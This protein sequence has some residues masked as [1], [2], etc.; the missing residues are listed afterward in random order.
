MTQNFNPNDQ[1]SRYHPSQFPNRPN[2]ISNRINNPIPYSN[3]QPSYPSNPNPQ[4]SHH[5]HHPHHPQHP[6]HPQQHSQELNQ[7][8]RKFQSPES[9]HSNNKYKYKKKFNNYGDNR[10]SNFNQYPSNIPYEEKKRKS[11]EKK[12]KREENFP[13]NR[14]SNN[15]PSMSRKV[16][17]TMSEKEFNNK[18]EIIRKNHPYPNDKHLL[19]NPDCIKIDKFDEKSRILQPDAP[20][21]QYYS[22]KK[23]DEI[24][25]VNHWG[26]RKLLMSEIEFLTLYTD[27][28]IEKTIVYAGAAPGT[29][30]NYLSGLFPACNF[31]LVDPAKFLAEPNEKITLRNDYMTDAIAKEYSDRNDILYVSDIRVNETDE[32]LL[33]DNQNQMN[34]HIIMKPEA[35]MLKFKCPYYKSEDSSNSNT[36]KYLDGDIFLPV[37]GRQSTT[38]CRLVVPKDYKIKEYDIKQYEEQLFYFNC[39]TRVNYYPHDIESQGLCHCFDCRSE[40]YILEQYLKKFHKL[41][42]TDLKEKIESMIA[43]ISRKCSPHSN[44]TL[45][46]IE[47]TWKDSTVDDDVKEYKQ[48]LTQ[49]QPIPSELLENNTNNFNR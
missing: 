9:Y 15:L 49:N 36:Y 42:D 20:C 22:R 31:V 7:V 16:E 45:D 12:R 19:Q 47:P 37:W 39:K 13:R 3:H 28:D 21:L 33:L 27:P 8:Y 44:R 43:E 11:E 38:E 26:Q 34:W 30:I 29:H 41:S 35:S 1:N 18:L 4:Y 46:W 5:P 14:K 32:Q 25:T 2:E 40:V 17:R 10:N 48:K 24:I 6:Q 23:R